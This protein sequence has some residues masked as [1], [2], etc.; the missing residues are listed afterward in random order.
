VEANYK[1]TVI[2][3]LQ[4]SFPKAFDRM[5]QLVGDKAQYLE[6]KKVELLFYD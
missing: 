6:F 3:N 2:D 1:V 4:N 5:K